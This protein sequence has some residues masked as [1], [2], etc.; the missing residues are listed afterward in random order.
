[1]IDWA[2]EIFENPDNY[3]ILDTETTGLGD[4]DV[5]IQ[6]GIINLHGEPLVNTLIKPTKRKR[7][8]NSA[9]NVH[10]ISMKMLENAPTLNEVFPELA[11]ILT[12][13]TPIIYNAKFDVRLLLQTYQQDEIK[14]KLNV[15][16]LCAMTAYSRFVGEWNEY[17]NDY[18]FQKLPSGDHSA[19]GDCK[20]TLNVLHEMART[21]KSIPTKKKWM[22]WK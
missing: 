9:T 17:Y 14:E 20:A 12:K 19:I 5:I 3:V 16:A 6:I 1:M 13:K 21:E 8:S 15:N 11:S 2:R 22:F 4:N 18:K 7:I 10:G